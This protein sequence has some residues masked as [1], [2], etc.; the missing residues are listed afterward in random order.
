MSLPADLVELI[1]SFSLTTSF[2][3]DQHGRTANP[4]GG[5]TGIGNAT[6]KRLL[7]ALR[8]N[9][10]VVLTSGRTARADQYRMPKSADLAIFTLQG[11]DELQ[12]QPSGTQR[13]IVFGKNQAGSFSGAITH[14]NHLGY[15]RIHVEFGLTGYKSIS[16]MFDKVFLSS[17]SR[18]GLEAFVSEHSLTPTHQ[19]DLGDLLVWAC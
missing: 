9:S 17:R 16:T 11:V 12:L 5:S 19:F 1:G 10:E 3:V 7:G 13:L 4:E 18:S 14:L 8:A 15:Q 6:D 2:V